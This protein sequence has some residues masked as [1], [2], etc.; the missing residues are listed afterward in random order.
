[1]SGFFISTFRRMKLT[2]E[3]PLAFFDLET[4]GVKDRS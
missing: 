2:L 3:R 4:T 1:M